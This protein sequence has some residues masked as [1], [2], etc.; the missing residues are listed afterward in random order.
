[1]RK[2]YS[3]DF[4]KQVVDLYLTGLSSSKIAERF[5]ICRHAPLRWAEKLGY[6]HRHPVRNMVNF[7]NERDLSYLYGVYRGDGSVDKKR[8]AFRVEVKNIEFITSIKNSFINIGLSPKLTVSNRHHAMHILSVFSKNLCDYILTYPKESGYFPSSVDTYPID[9]VRGVYESDGTCQLQYTTKGTPTS[10]RWTLE[11]ADRYCILKVQTI[12]DTL[13]INT[14]LFNRPSKFKGKETGVIMWGLRSLGG[15]AKV[16]EFM[17]IIKPVIKYAPRAI[18]LQNK[19]ISSQA[20]STLPEGSQT[21]G[22]V[23]PS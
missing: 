20:G 23:Q 5:N 13:K 1:M 6:S 18:I 3:K 8:S 9:F 15:H 4:K 16:L 11:M 7:S 21:S 12:L 22:E 17:T 19:L 2:T 14:S 10:W